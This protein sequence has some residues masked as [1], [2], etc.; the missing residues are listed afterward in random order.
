MKL[1]KDRAA[2]EKEQLNWEIQIIS[3]EKK[4]L[5]GSLAIVCSV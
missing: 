3:T 4:N 5:Q 2:G 1:L